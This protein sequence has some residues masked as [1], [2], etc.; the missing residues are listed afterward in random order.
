MDHLYICQKPF[1]SLSSKPVE[2]F[3]WNSPVSKNLMNITTWVAH[4]YFNL[5]WFSHIL[6]R[7]AMLLS[8]ATFLSSPASRWQNQRRRMQIKMPLYAPYRPRAPR[9]DKAGC[10]IIWNYMCKANLH[11]TIVEKLFFTG[12]PYLTQIKQSAVRPYRAAQ[13]I[14][15]CK[16]QTNGDQWRSN[17]FSWRIRCLSENN[18]FMSRLESEQPLQRVGLYHRCEDNVRRDNVLST[19]SVGNEL[20]QLQWLWGQ[21]KQSS[22]IVI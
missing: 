16:N 7:S 21:G 17:Y 3:W 14:R 18:N 19:V 22:C 1:N 20:S 13:Q 10:I 12:S 2:L 8:L 5:A 4:S 11:R 6:Y 15:V 9:R